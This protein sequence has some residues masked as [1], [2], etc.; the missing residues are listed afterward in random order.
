[1]P[2]EIWDESR[3][4]WI[5]YTRAEQHSADCERYPYER[6]PTRVFL[7]TSIVNLIVKYAPVIFEME[8]QDRETPL[9]RARDVEALMHVF[10][11]GARANW[12]LRASAKTLEEVNRTLCESTRQSLASFV[13]EM[14][15]L[16]TE[17]SRHGDD[18]GRRLADSSLLNVLPDRSDRELLGNAI[19]LGCDAFVT[20]DLRTIV[21]KR[22]RLPR[23]PLQILTPTEWCSHVKPWGGLWL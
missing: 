8:P 16:A 7:D 22:D 14:L 18:L 15:E 11:V 10:S 21:S 1:M 4:K 6:L 2:L 19:G 12:A 3:G 23:L 9:N 5:M 20:A 17:E 13:S